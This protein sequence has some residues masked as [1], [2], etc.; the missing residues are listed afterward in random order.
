[1]HHARRSAA[2]RRL[3]LRGVLRLGPA[4]D[5]WHKPAL[6]VVI[7][8]GV[9]QVA[10]L[11]AG[12]LDLAYYTSVGALCALYTHGLPYA[13]RARTL[14]LLVLGM[15]AG[16]GVALTTAAL[17]D[18]TAVRVAVAALLA[19]VHKTVCDATRL[20]PPGPVVLTFMAATAAFLPQ[21]PAAVPGHL[22]LGLGA[23]A[24]A[25]AVGMAPALL[26]PHGPERIAV[27]RALG[28]TARLLHETRAGAPGR[29]T[30]R[31]R[32]E[33]HAATTAAWHTLFLVPAD[34]P[35]LDALQR[36][37]VRAESAAAAPGGH[38]AE[39]D[40]IAGWGDELR[41]G[42]ALPQVELGGPGEAA[43]IAG[44][45]AE[46]RAAAG[47][48]SGALRRALHR[49]SPLLPIGLRAFVG[50][51]L[52]GWLSMGAGVGR[53]YWAVVTAASVF[54]ANSTLSWR[55]GLQ[56]VLGS[57][58]G[59]LLFTALVPVLR[60]GPAAVV[61]AALLCQFATEATVS[62]NYWLGNVFL[63][64]MAL[65]MTE[66]AGLQPAGQLVADRWLDTVVGAAAGLLACALVVNRHLGGQVETALERVAAA[67]ARARRVLAA[68][69]EAAA[70]VAARD[71]LGAALVELREAADTAAG[72]WWLGAL[73]QE[74]IATAERHGHQLLA[75]LVRLPGAGS[76]PCG[77]PVG[78]GPR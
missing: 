34:R 21:Q 56:R 48:G 23:G 18:S 30:H 62:R 43:E 29:E 69:G 19:A 12:R 16:V 6:S 24:F 58:V 35:H 3:P 55:R 75:D 27:A 22:A 54:Q 36:L 67:E 17:T 8:A 70:A 25:W 73:P 1:M 78:G 45:A 59:L 72:E 64:P 46:R 20:G 44:V 49:H 53:P 9:P 61:L 31:L 15:L 26:R 52:A 77:A 71:Q 76:R 68:G 39:A 14:A 63:T 7:A 37:L 10:L 13:R 32:H 74:R 60:T 65:M 38:A 28:A 5:I 66:F 33:A 4:A 47:T 50:T 41:R 51:A 42:R 57:M 2:A 40:R 11:A